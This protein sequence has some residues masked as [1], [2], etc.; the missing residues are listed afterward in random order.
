MN[1]IFRDALPADV[2][3][4][5]AFYNIVGGETSYLSFEAG[6]YPLS[7]DDLDEMLAGVYTRPNCRMLLALDGSTIV[8]IATLLSPIKLKSRHDAELGIVVAQKYQKLG[9][10]TELISRLID[11]A[12]GNGITTRISLETRA[13]NLPAIGLYLRFGFV[14]EGTKR[15]Q[16]LLGGNYYDAYIMGLL[17]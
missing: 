13:D 17:L 3:E 6:E 14:I 1:L 5:V 12:R 11:W 16:T 10:G 15:R 7:P 2:E 8:G 4:I 9:I